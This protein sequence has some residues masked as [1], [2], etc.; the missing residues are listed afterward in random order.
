M[1][2]DPSGKSDLSPTKRALLAL[3][4]M[5]AKVDRLER[6]KR[7]P[8]AVVGMGCRFP[9]GAA[10][11]EAFWQLL[12]EGRDAMREVP[13]ARWDIEAFYNPDPDVPGKMYTRVGGFLDQVDRFDPQFFGIS[14]RET[15]SMD[16]HQRLVLEVTWEALENAHMAPDRLYNSV[17]G[18]FVG[19]TNTEFGA[20]LIWNNDPT[21]IS[22]YDASGGSLGVAAGRL[23]YIMGFTGPSLT[24]DTACSSSLVTTHLAC[25][26]LRLGECDMAISAGVNLIF[27][28]ETFINF[29]K[30]HMLAPDGHCKTFDAAADGYARGEGCGVVVLKRL[31][32]ALRDGDR[33]HALLR[34][35]A[36][37]QDG[38]S[39]GLTVPNGPS[40]VRVIRNALANGGIDP[41]EVGLIEA[42]GTGTSLG[43]P[44]EMGALGTV[45]GTRRPADKPLWVGSVKTNFGH[46]ES[47]A[48]IAGLI[49]AILA[50]EHGEIPPHMNFNHPSPHIDWANL[51]VRIPRTPEPWD[52]P[53]RVAGVSSFSF[54]GTNAHI[55][56]SAWHPDENHSRPGPEKSP[57]LTTARIPDGEDSLANPARI[58]DGEDSLAN[59]ARISNGTDS[60]PEPAS[61]SSPTAVILP[62]SA[63]NKPALAELAR[64]H[65]ARLGQQPP[66]VQDW[67]AWCAAAGQGRNHFNERLAVVASEPAQAA[68]MLASLLPG[69]ADPSPT[70]APPAAGSGWLGSVPG[71]VR[72]KVVFLFTGQ[73]AQ[74]VG[75]ARQLYD[76]EPLFRA[77][78]EQCDALLRPHLERS[79][80]AMLYPAPG[81]T[82]AEAVINST[83]NTQPLLFAIEYALAQLWISWGITP[84]AVLGHSVGEYVAACLAGVFSLEEGLRLIAARG[85]LM[86]THCTPGAMLA[87]TLDEEA[88]REALQPYGESLAIATLNGPQRVVVAGESQAVATLAAAL[89]E[90]GV[91]NKRL[92]VSHAFHSPLMQPMLAPFRQEVSRIRCQKP[93]LPLCSNLTGKLADTELTDPEYWCRHV[94]QPVRFAAG[95]H[96]LIEAGYRLFLEVGPKPVLAHLGQAFQEEVFPTLR[97]TWLTTLRQNRDPHTHMLQTLGQLYVQG[98]TPDWAAVTPGRRGLEEHL[99]NYPFQRQRYWYEERKKSAFAMPRGEHPLLGAPLHSPGFAEG[100]QV[101]V[102]HLEP[103]ASG[104]LA[105]HRIFSAV[106][107]PAAAFVEMVLAAGHLRLAAGKLTLEAFAIHKALVFPEQ[108]SRQVQVVLRPETNGF[109][110]DIFSADAALTTEWMLHAS[111]R[112]TT[113]SEQEMIP[114]RDMPHLRALGRTEIPVQEFYDLVCSVGIFHDERFQALERL[115]HGD[116]VIV[117]ALRLPEVLLA[118]AAPYHL[119]PVLLDAA[120]QMVGA[121]LLHHGLAYLPVGMERLILH[122]RPDMHLWCRVTKTS[123]D[124][125][126]AARFHTADLEL[127]TDQGVVVVTIEGLRFQQVDAGALAGQLPVQKWLYTPT[128]EAREWTDI[129]P[130]DRSSPPA[131]TEDPWLILADR[132]GVGVSLAV[133]L[134]K[135]G[136]TLTL[137]T[138]SGDSIPVQELAP[139]NEKGIK[140]LADAGVPIQVLDPGNEEGIR[141]LLERREAS[142][143]WRGIVFAW[144]LDTPLA[145]NLTPTSLEEAQQQGCGA[146]LAL[147]QALLRLDLPQVP[148]LW[149]VTRDAVHIPGSDSGNAGLAQATLW[150]LGRVIATE[151]PNLTVKLLDLPLTLDPD[152]AA[153]SLARELSAQDTGE[154][155]IALRDAALTDAGKPGNALRDAALTD[156]GKPGN[157]THGLTRFVARLT[158]WQETTRQPLPVREN[159]RHLIVGGLGG[160]GLEVAQWLA[161]TRG[162]RHLVLMGRS[163][164]R[165]EILPRLD[166]LRAQGVEVEV[167]QADIAD[168]GQVAAL[169]APAAGNTAPWGGV[170]H[171]AGVL[172]D[173]MLESLTWPRFQKVMAAKVTGAWNLHQATASLHLD[174]FVLFSS[175]ASLF[176]S[177]AQANYAAANAFLDAL[178]GHRRQSGLPAMVINWGPWAEIGAAANRPASGNLG[179]KGVGSLAPAEGLRILDHCFD[180][181][182]GH[183]VAGK[184]QWPQ[185]LAIPGLAT[186]FLAHFLAQRQESG[187]RQPEFLA[188]LRELP[189]NEQR[190]RLLEHVKSQLARVLGIPSSRDIDENKGFFDL[191]MDSLTS[192]ELRNALQATLGTSLSST[193]LFKF[194]TPLALGTHL[195]EKLLDSKGSAPVPATP[196]TPVAPAETLLQDVKTLSDTDIEALINQEFANLVQG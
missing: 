141:H 181:P 37:N 77:T 65:Q 4:T 194:T 64:Q 60:R 98:V 29:C 83:A 76:Q 133:L 168:A 131:P 48:G 170:I 99:P 27:G 122:R 66:A 169:L 177:P 79:L 160:L 59:P 166:A 97:T 35:S 165:P 47:A 150:G 118:D 124:T 157:D 130:A 125:E 176:G 22:G 174:Y 11:P 95:L 106:T 139:G 126:Q 111:G 121:L 102:N 93:T 63:K 186:P 32:D 28:P 45:F 136:S 151:L 108:G 161:T 147:V 44:I 135:T 164:A 129:D 23:S 40:Q 82:D 54:S 110:F 16:P 51:P 8:I 87:I 183:I 38:P 113:T 25:Q 42:H 21:R 195:A 71:G 179:I 13:P 19:M 140:Y 189:L 88:V 114:D 10:T 134:K 116:G 75:M 81:V 142:Q 85:R 149:L 127:L 57:A 105:H 12:R 50:V 72:P 39:G 128:W 143:P 41:A 144:G 2:N 33:I 9:G 86:V 178:G 73:G 84:D 173:G 26:S 103:S 14:P 120:L 196:A 104:F 91:E 171:A 175:M 58:P 18:V 15:Q 100:V 7:E 163:P 187:T 5:Q 78:L 193:L 31:S 123:A 148:A 56:L 119:H 17:T 188:T 154:R 6:E 89:D 74:Y 190:A 62:L 107:L 49:K 46:L 69:I 138:R 24:L 92:Q 68:D 1:L 52:A 53:S 36:V 61:P 155:Q 70:A 30:A 191:G 96:T 112:V 137:V 132:G 90:R 185:L 117:G 156:A 180:H 67:R 109:A 167:V 43:D 158:P 3:Q 159:A 34:G 153:A 101:H 184:V 94:R 146:V 192:V 182:A 162:A 20:N 145:P 55:V 80:L 115:W 152:H 172:D